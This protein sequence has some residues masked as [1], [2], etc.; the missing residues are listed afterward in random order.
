MPMTAPWDVTVIGGGPAGMSAAL[1]LGRA[2]RRVLLL[3]DGRYRNYASRTLHGYLT[4]DGIDPA[5]FRAIGRDELRRYP[6]VTTRAAEVTDAR[7]VDGAAFELEVPGAAPERTRKLLLATG[8]VDHLPRI[9]GVE[10][11]YG[12]GVHHCPYCDGWELRDRPLAVYG[13]GDAKGAGL[14]LELTLWSAH[15]VLCTDGPPEITPGCVEK[16]RRHGIAVRTDPILRLEG[17]EHLERIAFVDG[18]TLERDALFFNTGR[19]QRSDL[20]RRLGCDLY[21]ERGCR[22]DG[23]TGKTHVRGLYVV[24]DA[25]RNV[26]QLIVAAAEGAEAAIASN[27]ELLVDDGILE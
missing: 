19:H 10:R 12:R 7:R 13:R 27:R 22:V 3:D 5:E 1:V 25:S 11:L 18:S 4:R 20:A 21:D 16:L 8:V 24:G 2:R 17:Q 26:L 23:I 6:N 14:A 9:E 15:V